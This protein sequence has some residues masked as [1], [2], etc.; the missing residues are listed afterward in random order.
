MPNINYF[1]QLETITLPKVGKDFIADA[2]DVFCYIYSDFTN[3]ELNKESKPQPKTDLAI[4]EMTKNATFE[5]MFN[6]ETDYL[7]QAQIIEFCKN[8]KEL[9]RQDGYATF[10]L[11]KVKD[12]YFVAHVNVRSYGLYVYVHRLEYDIVW[13]AD[14]QHRFVVPQLALST[15]EISPLET[16]TLNKAIKLCK[17]NGFRVI[18]EM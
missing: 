4:L 15:L 18:K 12:E 11:F 3:W 7:T 1:K 16:L 14:Y 2:K 9:L 10:F 5:Q 8:H 13:Y 17:N 6:K